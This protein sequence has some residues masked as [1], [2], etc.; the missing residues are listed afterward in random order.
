MLF[1]TD[2]DASLDDLQTVHSHTIFIEASLSREQQKESFQHAL[3]HLLGNDF[4]KDN[5]DKIEFDAHI[6]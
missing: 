3:K 1:D 6:A 4:K 2:Q 5:A